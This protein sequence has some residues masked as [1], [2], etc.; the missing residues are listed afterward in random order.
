MAGLKRRMLLV[1]ALVLLAGPI[2]V[3]LAEANAVEIDVYE[4][5]ICEQEIVLLGGSTEIVLLTGQA[6][7]HVFFEGPEEGTAYDNDSNTLDEVQTEM[8]ELDLRGY[9]AMLGPVRMRLNT[10][11]R[12]TGMME[13]T[14]N[15]RSGVLDVP[16]F[17]KTGSVESFFDVFFEVEIPGQTLYGEGPMRWRG[18]LREKPAGPLDLY[19]NQADIRLLNAVGVPSGFLWGANRFRPNPLVEIDV[20]ET[21]IC[22]QQVSTPLGMETVIMTGQVTEHVFFEGAVEGSANDDDGNG[23]EEVHTEMVELDLHGISPVLGLVRMRL[24]TN[25]RSMGEMEEITDSNTGILD[26]P[27]FAQNGT[28]E[29]FFD[30]FFE[31]EM[32][33]QV[34]YGMD[35][36]HLRGTLT[37]KPAGPLD[38]YENLV[39]I[40]LMDENGNPTNIYFSAGRYRPNLPVETDVLDTSIGSLVLTTPSGQ[41]YA[42]G[43]MGQSEI[44]V[45]FEGAVE[46]AA[47]DDDGDGLDDVLTELVE[48]DLRGFAPELGGEVR[49]GLDPRTP[50]HGEMEETADS[51][52]GVLD[53]PPFAETGMIDSFFDVYFEIEFAGYVMY[54]DGP[55]RLR[56]VFSEKPAAPGDI[57]KNLQD[58]ALVDANGDPTGFSLGATW[59]EPIACG[60]AEHP[61]PIG[62]LNKDC[63][64]NFFDIA[65]LAL[66]WLDCTR[67]QCY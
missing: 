7:V 50:T 26:V 58:V 45:F 17:A 65:I 10:N 14:I 13:E 35:P 4:T 46:G 20:Y 49:M 9:S 28:V 42:V 36:M 51:N 16:P 52:M 1:C 64:V 63:E 12:S 27:P 34:F 2:Q 53:V 32:L 55:M 24:N 59:Y 56:G 3:V 38:I 22:E 47:N 15:N 25:Y 21:V 30:V 18:L 31:L 19:E 62:D 54:G 66:H 6:T 43:L 37:Q 44:H 60:D 33:G 67:P 57:Y 29:S 48:L 41:E 39:D 11:Y 40:Q 5:V 23:R 8:V 61:Y